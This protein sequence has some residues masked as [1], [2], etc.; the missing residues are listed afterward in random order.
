M[1]T[2]KRKKPQNRVWDDDTSRMSAD[3]LSMLASL[4]ER[5][6]RAE[7]DRDA[8]VAYYLWTR[9]QSIERTMQER[10]ANALARATLE[11]ESRES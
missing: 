5:V 6:V 2:T 3:T 10:G 11:R 1:T 7:R 4:S 8:N 9:V